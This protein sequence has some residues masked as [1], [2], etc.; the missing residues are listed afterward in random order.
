MSVQGKIR[1]DKFRLDGKAKWRDV[2]SAALE[3]GTRQH[4]IGTLRI[5][6]AAG[7]SI[8]YTIRQQSFAHPVYWSRQNST[9]RHV[10]NSGYERYSKGPIDVG[11]QYFDLKANPSVGSL[12]WSED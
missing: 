9:A 10:S 3:A 2:K 6:T 8:R 5:H 7:R 11:P 12:D 4:R 1:W